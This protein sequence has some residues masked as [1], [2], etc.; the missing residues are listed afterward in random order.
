M[1]NPLR[2]A[3]MPLICFLSYRKLSF[4]SAFNTIYQ[5]QEKGQMFRDIVKEVFKDEYPEDADTFSFVTQSDLNRMADLLCLSPGQWFADLA[6]GRGGPGMWLARKTGANITG[7]DI[8]E[9]A[10]TKACQRV[11]E[12]GLEGRASFGIGSFYDTGIESDSCHGAVSVDA[13]WLAPDRDRALKEVSRILKPGA[14][15]V[16]TTWDGNIPFSPRD[17]RDNLKNAGFSIETYIETKG[18][19]Q[20]QLAVYEKVLASADALIQNMGKSAAMAIIREAKSTPQV[21]E[22][23]TR[24]LVAARKQ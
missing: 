15:F 10:V 24:V 13:L 9:T 7:V 21:L 1:K 19:K 23:S 11:P 8:S 17:H 16:F 12:F 2:K 18:W 5:G 6:C 3:I 20:R 22:K 14:C 4:K